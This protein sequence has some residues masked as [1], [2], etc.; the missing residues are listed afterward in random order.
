M[1]KSDWNS[2]EQRLIIGCLE[3]KDLIAC[4]KSGSSD[5]FVRTPN[6]LIPSEL[7]LILTFLSLG[8]HQG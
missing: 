7:V 1:S 6:H 8:H 3:A 5:P 4:D 2:S